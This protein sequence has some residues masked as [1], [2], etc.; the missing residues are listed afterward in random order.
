M[1]IPVL[2]SKSYWPSPN[3]TI[4]EQNGKKIIIFS[5]RVTQVHSYFIIEWIKV[6]DV[7]TSLLPEEGKNHAFPRPALKVPKNQNPHKGR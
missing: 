7:P 1:W 6:P 5:D 4:T 3:S 2:I